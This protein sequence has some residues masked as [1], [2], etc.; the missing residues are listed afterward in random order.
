MLKKNDYA[1]S[2]QTNKVAKDCSILGQKAIL[3]TGKIA[4]WPEWLF[5]GSVLRRP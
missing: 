3:G 5:C 4:F 1:F 2:E